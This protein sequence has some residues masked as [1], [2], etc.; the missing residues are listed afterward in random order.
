MGDWVVFNGHWNNTS[1][2]VYKGGQGVSESIRVNAGR[3]TISLPFD[4][5]RFK[6][7]DQECSLGL[8]YCP[9]RSLFGDPSAPG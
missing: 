7:Y 1:P 5:S 8:A 6:G 3:W 2:Y 9:S 4:A